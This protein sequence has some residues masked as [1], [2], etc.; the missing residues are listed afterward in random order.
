MICRDGIDGVGVS[1]EAVGVVRLGV[2][3]RDDVG[4]EGNDVADEKEDSQNLAGC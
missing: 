2:V 1:S 4:D 3:Q